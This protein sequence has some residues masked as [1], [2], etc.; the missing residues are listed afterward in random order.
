MG[1]QRPTRDDIQ[2]FQ[3]SIRRLE[4]LQQKQ[5]REAAEFKPG[6]LTP[7]EE[8]LVREKGL[9]ALNYIPQ[10]TL[11]K[12]QEALASPRKPASP[13]LGDDI[14]ERVDGYGY[15]LL[16]PLILFF[17]WAIAE[18]HGWPIGILCGV[19]MFAVLE[20]SYRLLSRS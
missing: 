16:V 11:Q 6:E 9:T 8:E 18:A 3:D 15:V 10:R 14:R 19:L 4:E 5:L 7:E 20:L 13:D 1:K 12:Q 2:Q 17:A